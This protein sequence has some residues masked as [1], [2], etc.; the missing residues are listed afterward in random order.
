[1]IRDPFTALDYLMGGEDLPHRERGSGWVMA[2][3][4]ALLAIAVFVLRQA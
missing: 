2:I 4:L 1:M 3:L